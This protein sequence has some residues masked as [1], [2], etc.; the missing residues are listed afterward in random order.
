[1]M[2]QVVMEFWRGGGKDDHG[3]LTESYQDDLRCLELSRKE[4]EKKARDRDECRR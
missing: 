2:K 3:E 4:T 1:M